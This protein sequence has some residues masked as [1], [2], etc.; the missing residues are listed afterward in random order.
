MRRGGKEIV[1]NSTG[2]SEDFSWGASAGRQR[3]RRLE[4]E[5]GGEWGVWGRRK[6]GGVIP[7]ILATSARRHTQVTTFQWIISW[8]WL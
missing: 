8:N 6:R 1:P 3:G 2:Y 7:P 5:M 4:K